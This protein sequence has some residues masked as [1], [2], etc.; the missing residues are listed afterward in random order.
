M[1]TA[2]EEKTARQGASHLV[3][4]DKH[5]YNVSV[6]WAVIDRAYRRPEGEKECL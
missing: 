1:C 2:V 4:F 3:P 6:K 5:N